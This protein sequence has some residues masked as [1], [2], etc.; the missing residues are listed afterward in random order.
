MDYP[1]SVLEHFLGFVDTSVREDLRWSNNF[2]SMSVETVPISEVDD[3]GNRLVMSE[4]KQL[5][6]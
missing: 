4:W 2:V 5:L 6:D 1:D 3:E